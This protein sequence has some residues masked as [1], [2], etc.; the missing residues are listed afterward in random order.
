[1][2]PKQKFTK[3]EIISVALRLVRRHG[4]TG[5]T[6]RGLGAELGSSS[7]P[8]F[9]AFRSME[10]V[11]Q[12]TIQ[13][14]KGMYNSY[15]EK[16]LADDIPFKGVGM[17]YIRFACDEPKLFA[18]LFMTANGMEH[19][20]DDILP[21]IDDNSDRILASIQKEYGLTKEVSYRLYQKMWIF[22]HGVACLCA[23]GVSILPEEEASA[24]LTEVFTGLLIKIKKEEHND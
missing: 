4:I 15:V 19:N 12:E 6:A 5:I 1:M 24:L 10:E 22:T 16:G 2:P 20:L 14:A 21:A 8:V 13:A 18:L 3:E 11:Q 9:T 23:T 7:H 17:Q